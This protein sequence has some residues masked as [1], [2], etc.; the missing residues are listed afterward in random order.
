MHMAMMIHGIVSLVLL[1][2][3]PACFVIHEQA[4]VGM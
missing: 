4:L 1:H 3:V 2:L